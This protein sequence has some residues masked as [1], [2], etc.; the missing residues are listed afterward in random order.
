MIQTLRARLRRHPA[1]LAW[2][3][4]V[5]L[6][7]IWGS[8]FILIKKAV[9]TY[10]PAALG[11]L[12]IMAAGLFLLPVTSGIFGRRYRPHGVTRRQWWLLA[13]L[14]LTGSLLPAVLFSVAGRYVDSALSGALNALTPLFTLVFGALAFR[15]SI[16]GRGVVGLLIGL[17]GTL[18][19]VLNGAGGG[20]SF[21]AYALCA[22]AATVC[23]GVNTNLVKHYFHDLHPLHI[24]SLSLLLMLPATTAYFFGTG[25]AAVAA[26]PGG[27]L[28]TLYVVLLGV[29]GTALALV[30]FNKLV[31]I[32]TAVFA[33][34]VTYLIP[35]VALAWGAWDGETLTSMQLLGT[36][37]VI[38]GVLLVNRRR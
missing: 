21:N 14:G 5:A 10:D 24:T 30:L 9:R 22:V 32:S 1:V 35:V 25:G 2:T 23:Y 28:P 27:A 36:G 4:L 33:S 12:R 29:L 16:S 3:L 17:A 11:T 15:H 13:T 34:A 18:M 7:L 26:Q 31:Q 20:I 6:S 8:S 37:A 19:L 38:G